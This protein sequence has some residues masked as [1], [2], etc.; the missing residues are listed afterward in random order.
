MKLSLS[1]RIAES[2]KRKDI[3][4]VPVEMVAHQ[5]KEILTMMELVNQ[6]ISVQILQ[7]E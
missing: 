2:P 5:A 7:V 4:A 1:V 3:T 6:E